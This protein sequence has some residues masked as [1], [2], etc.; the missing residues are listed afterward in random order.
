MT[1]LSERLKK[2]REEKGLS[3]DEAAEKL[4]ISA[5]M[6]SAWER[7]DNEPDTA[8]VFRMAELYSGS[9]DMILFGGEGRN[10]SRTMFPKEAEPR[11]SAFADWKVLVGALAA[12]CG[13][14][15]ILLMIMRAI[16]EGYDTF[17]G[18][19]GFCGTSLIIFAAVFLAG[20]IMAGVTALCRRH[21]HNKKNNRR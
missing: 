17:E 8:T 7:G 5:E 2:Y 19:M 16:G 18:M 10:A 9:A 11:F 6:L 20:L 4:G 12:F 1:A 3:P 14:G 13:I 15:G 21:A